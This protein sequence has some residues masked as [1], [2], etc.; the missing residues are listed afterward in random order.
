MLV[1]DDPLAGRAVSDMLGGW[2]Y[3]VQWETSGEEAWTR[4]QQD[5]PPAVVI[6]DWMLPDI[7]GVE[8][9]RRIRAQHQ[10]PVYIIMLT[11]RTGGKDLVEGLQAGA[12]DYVSKPFDPEEMKA[13]LQV[14]VRV[15]TLEQ[16]LAARVAE[17]EEAL[18]Q[19]Q[20]LEGL[21]PICAY[22]K[23]IRDDGQYWRQV[24]EYIAHHTKVRFSHGI[25]PDCM[26][27]VLRE[28]FGDDA[29]PS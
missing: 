25:C 16:A 26:E 8:I 9:C 19:V 29:E 14:G 7:D 11:A 22:C 4:M 28:E 23:K 20:Q 2:G 17:L 5:D 13:R 18:E 3:A 27:R 1:E 24:D 15:A 12:D 21:L 6:L 10:R